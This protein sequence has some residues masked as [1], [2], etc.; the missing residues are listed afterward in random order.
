MR[1]PALTAIVVVALG[2]FSGA[3]VFREQIAQ[4]AQIVGAE[5]TSPLDAQGNVSVH[6][7]GTADI[8]VTNTSLPVRE[9]GTPTVKVGGPVQTESS[10]ETHT[11][12]D[13]ILCG[14]DANATYPPTTEAT[15]PSG[16][17]TSFSAI[18]VQFNGGG[19]LDFVVRDAH[20]EIFDEFTTS[21][22]GR[23]ARVYDVPPPTITLECNTNQAQF[24]IPG[25]LM[26][27]GWR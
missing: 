9:T 7:Q 20:G 24:S 14:R 25:R 13:G 8:N 1:R 4:A 6:E 22:N 23:F 18:R 17:P 2:L 21:S 12:F 15:N 16:V 11:A 10:D 27:F 5:I 19:N 26:I 3:T